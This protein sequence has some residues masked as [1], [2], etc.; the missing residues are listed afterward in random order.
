MRKIFTALIIVFVLMLSGCSTGISQTDYDNL[1][2]ERDKALSDKAELDAKYLESSKKI[3]DLTEAQ[4]KLSYPTAWAQAAFGDNAV[5]SS[6]GD[7]YLHIIVPTKESISESNVSECINN[8]ISS[9]A[10]LK[11]TMGK[12]P[13]SFPYKIISISFL[14]KD[15]NGI[16]TSEFIKNE[17]RYVSGTTLI[18]MTDVETIFA[19]INSA[20]K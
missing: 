2:S 7:D 20:L 15:D 17:D 12:Y 10:T 4:L 18:S 14:D 19:G 11:Y 13:L 9:A 16:L 3:L 5:I 8:V 6:F 1:I